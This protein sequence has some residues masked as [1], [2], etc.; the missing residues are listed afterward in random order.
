MK[1]AL[2]FIGIVLGGLLGLIL[3][4]AVGLYAKTKMQLNKT[5]DVQ[6]ESVVIPTDTESIEHGKHLATVLCAECHGDDLG[7][8]P[9]WIALP[10]LA[11]VSPPNLTAGQGSVTADFTDED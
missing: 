7:G 9:N 6:V 10:G 5:Y 2:K 4:A 1:R 11:V 3:L 8:M